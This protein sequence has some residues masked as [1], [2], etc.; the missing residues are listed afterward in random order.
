MELKVDN[1]ESVIKY[2]N[3]VVD[4]SITACSYVVKAA[5]RFLADLESDEYYFDKNAF[6]LIVNFI[7]ILNLNTAEANK[8]FI[9]ED[10]QKFLIAN[11]YGIKRA[12]DNKRKYTY[13]Y[14]EIPRK[15]GKS[16][17]IAALS[18][19]H[20][21]FDNNATIT[22]SANS[23]EQAKNV[24]FKKIKAFA[25]QLDNKEKHLVPY[26]NSLKFFDKGNEI[27]V[28]SSDSNRLD[29]LNISTAIIDEL[30]AAPDSS[31]YD[32]IKS[33][34]GAQS[35]PLLIVIT[36]AGFNPDGF[37]YSLRS[38]I[39]NVL[40]GIVKDEAQFGIIYTLDEG[41]DFTDEKNWVK[42]NPNLN[43]SLT[44]SFLKS[45]VNKAKVNFSEG[46]GIKVKNFNL[47]Q[48]KSSTES[49]IPDVYIERAFGDLKISNF[50]GAE[51]MVG[52]D[53]GTNTD[54]CALSFCIKAAEGFV[55][56]NRYYL[57]ADS[58]NTKTMK[59]QYKNWA[60]NGYIFLTE[61]NVTDYNYILN[62]LVEISKTLKIK[63]INY[64]KYNATQWAIDASNFFRL[65]PFSQNPFNYNI[66]T[67]EFERN[68]LMSKLKIENNPVTKW[69][70][71]NVVIKFDW[72]GNAKPIKV[73]NENK[74]DGVMSM[75]M[76]LGGWVG[77]KESNIYIV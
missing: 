52:V 16:E 1:F 38:H 63:Q 74:I 64:D 69:M 61:G 20:L 75:L 44:K 2:A 57:P 58:L 21:I 71:D 3:G 50:K 34:M 60:E 55:F 45:E 29:G 31:V 47:W 13:V 46:T 77:R 68:I 4:G 72:N 15:N 10:W 53:L 66:P 12:E 62:D 67:K 36:T 6:D 27:I 17:L 22:V 73:N 8:K 9:L 33:A 40:S 76:A 26:F 19:Y 25:K 14:I 35:E 56:F 54:I 59:Q 51:A 49:W 18:L 48:K 41:D 70:L 7:Q 43:V 42:A 32:V 28:T 5:K 23:R 37:C 11:I 39:A 30:H 65:K 24:D